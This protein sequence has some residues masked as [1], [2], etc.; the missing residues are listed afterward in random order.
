VK[1]YQCRDTRWL[2]LHTNQFFNFFLCVWISSPC[3]K[4][5]QLHQR[6]FLAVSFI[7]TRPCDVD[8]F[9]VRLVIAWAAR[10]HIVSLQQQQQQQH[11]TA[12]IVI[13][14]QVRSFCWASPI[15]WANLIQ[16]PTVYSCAVRL[17]CSYSM[18]LKTI[19][20]QKTTRD[21]TILFKEMATRAI[22]YDV[23]FRRP[24]RRALYAPVEGNGGRKH[25]FF[26]SLQ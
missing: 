22:G 1:V 15:E 14:K 24:W 11:G 21:R 3:L 20:V 4:L 13:I 16:H 5:H 19:K 26:L 10:M 23:T 2:Q 17:T 18:W 7:T 12:P 25:F 6:L 9:L 8:F